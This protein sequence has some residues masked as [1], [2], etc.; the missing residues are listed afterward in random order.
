MESKINKQ[1]EFYIDTAQMLKSI[2]VFCLMQ[3]VNLFLLS[4]LIHKYIVEGI[5]YSIASAIIF[6]LIYVVRSAKPSLTLNNTGIIYIHLFHN[7]EVFRWKEINS[8]N[9]LESRNKQ[10]IHS[11]TIYFKNEKRRSFRLNHL[12]LRKRHLINTIKLYRKDLVD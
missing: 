8:I 7:A 6:L 11:L 10:D 2:I 9:I 5:T 3:I 12:D 1:F 4:H